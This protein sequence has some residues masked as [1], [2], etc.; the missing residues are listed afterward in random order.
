[1]RVLKA[2]MSLAALVVLM[3]NSNLLMAAQ[4]SI[5]GRLVFEN[6]DVTCQQQCLVT[7][8]A[9]GGRP[10]ETVF[11]DLGGRFSFMNVP[12]GVHT[13][14]VEIEG[15]ETV[16][17]QVQDFDADFAMELVIPVTRRSSH[18]VSAGSDVVNISEFLELYPKNAVNSFE[19]GSEFLK[20]KKNK[21]AVKYL[22]NAVELAPT[23]YEAHY[24]LG[25][26]YQQAGRLDD[27]E[28]EF[29][30]AHQLNSTGVQPLLSLMQLYL[31][32]NE[33]SE[34]VEAGEQAVK[35]NSRSASAF[36]GLGVALY[37][38]AQLDRA[39]A[40]LKRA[41]DLAPKMANI[42]LVLANVYAKLR[43][44]DDTLEQ[45]NTYIAEN[46]RGDQV[47]EA[48]RMRDRLLEVKGPAQRQ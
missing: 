3:F 17:R 31:D 46:P 42:R 18:A 10:I 41:L 38:A 24:Q 19:K 14:R 39:E 2:S 27:A 21:E 22:K 26:A 34:A 28:Q 32:R 13:V 1:M 35:A 9:F 7:L 40:A 4:R 29:V 12:R 20:Q 37:K 44:Y 15:F 48:A 36:F 5:E 45:L 33:T 6:A 16:S 25:I 47:S 43:R 30:K 8:L 11:A 23:F